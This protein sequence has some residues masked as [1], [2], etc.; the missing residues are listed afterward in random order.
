MTEKQPADPLRLTRQQMLITSIL[1]P[2][3]SPLSLSI[4]EPYDMKLCQMCHYPLNL[5]FSED[6]T[7]FWSHSY[8]GCLMATITFDDTPENRSKW[9]G[10]L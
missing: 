5:N 4:K 9:N 8:Q 3:M 6:G 2:F 1:S 7:A 10:W